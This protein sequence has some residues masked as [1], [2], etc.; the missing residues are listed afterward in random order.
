MQCLMVSK[1]N[2]PL[3]GVLPFIQFYFT[4]GGDL[5]QYT[6]TEKDPGITMVR[7]LNSTEHANLLYS[8]ANQRLAS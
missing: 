3:I 4:M 7:T 6:D 2:P 8:K 1:F 5:L